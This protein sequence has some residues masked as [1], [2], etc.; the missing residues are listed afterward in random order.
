MMECYGNLTGGQGHSSKIIIT[1][2]HFIMWKVVGWFVMV[3]V[4]KIS[5]LLPWRVFLFEPPSLWKFQFGF[6]LSLKKSLA[7][8][9]PLPLGISKNPPWGGHRYFL[10]PHTHHLILVRYTKF[11][12]QT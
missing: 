11:F 2:S 7:F 12:T 6:I 3:L 5:I 8:E 9:I 10:E 4:Q 1:P